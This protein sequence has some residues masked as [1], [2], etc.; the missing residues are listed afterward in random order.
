MEDQVVDLGLAALTESCRRVEVEQ[1]QVWE[2]CRVRLQG[3]VEDLFHRDDLRGP[4]AEVPSQ[5]HSV[6]VS[7]AGEEEEK[8]EKKRR[9]RSA[10]ISRQVALQQFSYLTLQW[11][12]VST[13]RSWSSTPLQ[14]WPWPSCRLT[15]QGQEWGWG[16]LT[17]PTW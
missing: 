13:Q 11:R 14:K 8:E 15:C 17:P 2:Q 6:L 5:D 7:S 9:R 16:L 10:A 3:Q 12:A 4:E 1:R